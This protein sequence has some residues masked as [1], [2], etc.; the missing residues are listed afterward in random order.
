MTKILD[1]LTTSRWAMERGVL[2][3]FRGV[4]EAH[5]N[6]SKRDAA[7]IQAIVEKRDREVKIE[8]ARVDGGVAIIPISGVIA[9]HAKM[10]NGA[11]QPQGTSVAAIRKQMRNALG[12][13]SV[14][15]VLF[16]VE[17][18]GGSVQGIDDLA[19]EIRAARD[20][21]RIV[22]HTDSLM[23]SA[24]Y[25]LSSQAHE[26]Y[27]TRSADV[28]SIGVYAV[29]DDV[30]KHYEAQGIKTHVVSSGGQKG[31]GI[32]GTEIT[33]EQLDGFQSSV[34]AINDVF[35]G[36]VAT[37]RGQEAKAVRG[38]WNNG[39]TWMG[40]EAASMGLIDSVATFEGL[41]SRLQRE[42]GTAS[43]SEETTAA[44]AATN[45]KGEKMS[46]QEI[47]EVVDVS[48]D[49]D[50]ARA[51]GVEAERARVKLIRDA[52]HSSQR[53]IADVFVEDGESA[54][55]ATAMLHADLRAKFDAL[56]AASVER[57][58]EEAPSAELYGDANAPAVFGA[59]EEAEGSRR[60]SGQPL[61]LRR[62]LAAMSDVDFTA[63]VA[64]EWEARAAE[65]VPEFMSFEGFHGSMI[66]ARA[67]QG[68]ILG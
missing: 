44:R 23:A 48:A 60:S 9:P 54:D 62:D 32:Q 18:P 42:A 56:S 1:Y 12:D 14:H 5:L 21:K 34:N 67:E 41:L 7:D 52:A 27:A 28:G 64:A 30:S 45:S 25:W 19:E 24:A 43:E 8:D 11:S 38:A 66:G 6:G 59:V 22:A 47:V 15:T 33:D 10:V 35:V 37:G 26:V 40:A 36:A 65:L 68:V 16:N 46:E 31:A 20:S 49:L 3:R 61:E 29:V 55:T 51:D 63:A 57:E 53:E 4:L 13:P 58:V 39:K 17:S 50:Q 2:D